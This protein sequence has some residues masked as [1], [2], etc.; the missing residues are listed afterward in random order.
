MKLLLQCFEIGGVY[1]SAVQRFIGRHRVYA[2]RHGMGYLAVAVPH[3]TQG[4]WDK[5]RLMRDFLNMYDFIMYLDADAVVANM[6]VDPS[7]VLCNT[8]DMGGIGMVKHPHSIYGYHWNTGV[9][10]LQEGQ[11]RVQRFLDRWLSYQGTQHDHATAWEQGVL[12][13]HFGLE[14]NLVQTPDCWNATLAVND[15]ELPIVLAAHGFGP[16]EKRGE[17]LET[18]LK[19]RGMW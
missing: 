1:A 14:Y 12:N 8:K 13:E 6:A 11:C 2:Q 7:N 17:V 5:L 9:M 3:E 4:G 15:V 10:Y 18:E 16:M 19:K